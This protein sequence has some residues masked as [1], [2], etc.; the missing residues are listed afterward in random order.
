MEDYAL[1]EHNQYPKTVNFEKKNKNK[2]K[3]NP[4]FLC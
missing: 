1:V 3:K 2:E 4:L